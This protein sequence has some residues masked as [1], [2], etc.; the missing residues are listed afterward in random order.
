MR[1]FRPAAPPPPPP[2]CK[3]SATAACRR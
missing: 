3:L 2:W 1:G